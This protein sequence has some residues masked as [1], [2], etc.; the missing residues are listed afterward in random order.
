M[1]TLAATS[2]RPNSETL[3]VRM[4]LAHPHVA[5]D[6]CTCELH[7]GDAVVAAALNGYDDVGLLP[8]QP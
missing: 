7:K 2:S 1:K 6:P 8:R 5:F 3:A 4:V